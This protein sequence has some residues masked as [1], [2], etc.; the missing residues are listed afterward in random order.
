MSKRLIN[1]FWIIFAWGSGILF[2]LGGVDAMFD[3][4]Y[5]GNPIVGIIAIIMGVMIIRSWFK[6][7]RGRKL[8]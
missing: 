5:N 7:F 3:P 1:L 2:I 8:T 6:Q 4:K